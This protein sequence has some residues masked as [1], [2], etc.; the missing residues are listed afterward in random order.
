[1]STELIEIDK[2]KVSERMR[3]VNGDLETL[4]TSM[5]E[6]G[7]LQCIGVQLLND[8]GS[9]LLL[10]GGRRLAAAK[11]LEWKTIEAKI[12]PSMEEYEASELEFLENWERQSLTWQDE[13]QAIGRIHT[14]RVRANALVGEDWGQRET[15]RLLGKSVG[16]VNY[17]LKVAALLDSGDKEMFQADNMAEALRILAIRKEAEIKSQGKTTTPS[18]PTFFN[19]KDFSVQSTP[20]AAPKKEY[21]LHR[22]IPEIT[23]GIV[24]HYHLPKLTSWML[25]R[26]EVFSVHWEGEIYARNFLAFRNTS[27]KDGYPFI[28]CLEIFN[29]FRR[30]DFE[31]STSDVIPIFTDNPALDRVL[32]GPEAMTEGWWQYIFEAVGRGPVFFDYTFLDGVYYCLRH[33]IEVYARVSDE[34]VEKLVK[35]MQPYGPLEVKTS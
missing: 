34:N 13:C 20:V 30:E 35:K 21:I 12:A 11:E 6:R 27:V 15:G 4:R 17:T 22:Y 10:W 23:V 8:S 14:Q 19:P 24:G 28:P 29:F 18:T 9:Y 7:L 2:I 26:I 25:S 5:H 33:G 32:W 16:N 1:V 3:K 31:C